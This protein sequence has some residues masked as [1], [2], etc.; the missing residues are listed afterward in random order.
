MPLTRITNNIR[1]TTS[2]ER[3]LDKFRELIHGSTW[4]RSYRALE[5]VFEY[6]ERHR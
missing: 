3:H 4:V 1:E 2:D 6:E 5:K